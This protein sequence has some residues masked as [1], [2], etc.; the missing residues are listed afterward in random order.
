GM[1]LIH[2]VD[3]HGQPLFTEGGLPCFALYQDTGG[4]VTGDIAAGS[5]DGHDESADGTTIL[6]R[7]PTGDYILV[8]S[9]PVPGYVRAA[10]RQIH[11]TEG[12]TLEITIENEPGGTVVV[13]KEDDLG[14][15]L[16]GACFE[17]RCTTQSTGTGRIKRESQPSK[18]IIRTSANSPLLMD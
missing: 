2:K 9:V 8:E 10:D 12:E 18:A 5:C 1:L 3:E 13:R 14:L 16:T 17:P 11:V 6:D 4:G 7:L 15:L